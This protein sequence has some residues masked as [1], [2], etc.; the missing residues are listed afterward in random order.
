[1]KLLK[2]IVCRGEMIIVGNEKGVHK[3]VRCLSCGFSNEHG[4]VVVQPHS[5]SEHKKSPEVMV[6]RKRPLSQE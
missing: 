6:I 3:K 2:C 4:E 1:M 5:S